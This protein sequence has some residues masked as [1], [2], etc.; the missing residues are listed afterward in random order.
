LHKGYNYTFD[1]VNE[2]ILQGIKNKGR[3]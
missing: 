1:E 2:I 3:N